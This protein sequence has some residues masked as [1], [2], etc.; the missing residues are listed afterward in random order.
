MRSVAL[1]IEEADEGETRTVGVATF[2]ILVSYWRR[3]ILVGVPRAEV[4]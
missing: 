2:V 1:A 4:P 3:L